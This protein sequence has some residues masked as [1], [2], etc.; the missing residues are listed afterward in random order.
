VGCPSW[1]ESGCVMRDARLSHRRRFLV[2]VGAAVLQVV[3][4]GLNK[5]LNASGTALMNLDTDVIA[6]LRLR[7][8]FYPQAFAELYTW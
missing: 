4:S 8:R 1:T 2:R 7:M 3:R 6:G 5:T